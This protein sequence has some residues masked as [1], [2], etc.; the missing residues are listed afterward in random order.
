VGEPLAVPNACGT[1]S[2]GLYATEGST[3]AIHRLPDF[4]FA[5]Y[6]GGGVSL[7]SVAT[8]ETVEPGDGD[9]RARIQA[10]I[11]FVSTRPADA[12]GHRGAV[13]LRAGTYE[14]GDT[15]TI[16]TSGVVLRGEGQGDDGTV[17]HATKPEQHT[18]LRVQGSGSGL[19]ED[20][21]TRSIITD[22]YVPV[23]STTLQVSD[24]S[25][26]A[27]G[28][29]VVVERTPNDDWVTD[30]GMDAFGWTAESYHIGHERNITAI[31]GDTLTIDIPIVD[32]LNHTHGGGSVY[33][34]TVPGRLEEVGVEN[35]R[36]V[37]AFA[38]ATDEDH[39][40]IAVEL[41][42][43]RHSWVHGVT[44][45]HFGYSAV[46][47][48]AESAFNTVQEVAMLS[49]ISQVTG[50]RRYAFNVSDG[51]G[52]LFQR[53]YSEEARHDFVTGSRTTGPNVW[54]DSLSVDSSNDDGPHHRWSTGMMLDNVVS[55]KIHVENRK[56]SGSG[57]GWS[58]A[59]TLFWNTISESIRA[60]APLGAMNWTI[61]SMGTQDEGGWAPEEPFG[62]WESHNAP[63]EP[64]SL[65]LQQLTDRLSP[66]AVNAVTTPEQREGR[67]WGQL[68]EWAGSAPLTSVVA[69]GGDKTC[70]RGIAAGDS[71]CEAG[72]GAC[73]GSGC[74]GRPG[75][76]AACCT[77]NI[78][79]S[80][81]SCQLNEA[82]CI[83]DPLFVPI[84]E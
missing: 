38:S 2:Y 30:L 33:R 16:S 68:A 65:Y 17:L 43:T 64:R 67:I 69:T 47:I 31:D 5:G 28:D 32:A 58:G 75:G 63:V 55:F 51:I 6:R 11:D 36:I 12:S 9:D 7:P 80:G 34:T 35:L 48:S 15:I 45:V 76:A 60:D 44:A 20:T 70:E 74:G 41:R 54:L 10:A 13:L 59:Q 29:T 25:V 73:G 56:D 84:G 72:C 26:F 52:N 3:E 37:S 22:E 57:H 24:G 46:S 19:P 21:G 49:P 50:G 23:G 4:S 66:A 39:G 42:R 62:W 8:V 71:C 83:I 53:C 40:W 1:L 18:L 78:K 81:Q 77:G 14:V 61:G 27:V 79:T 82:P